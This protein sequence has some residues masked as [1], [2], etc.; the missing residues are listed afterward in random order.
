[1]VLAAT[2]LRNVF[3]GDVERLSEVTFSRADNWTGGHF[4]RMLRAYENWLGNGVELQILRLVGFADGPM[5]QAQIDALTSSPIPGVTDSIV[6]IGR[7]EWEHAVARLRKC[8][9]L[10]K[11]DTL[12]AHPLIREYFKR[13][14]R[15]QNPEGWAMAQKRLGRSAPAEIAGPLSLYV[16]I[17]GY[18]PEQ[19][20][21]VVVSLSDIY[22]T[23]SGDRLVIDG[24]GLVERTKIPEPSGA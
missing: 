2:Y 13:E 4:G 1:L 12:N 23:L 19:I 3:G 22:E 9:L 17:T 5:S 21:Q 14:I 24:Q 16:D 15:E 10:D 11:S 6:G 20:A 18:T 7:R 8:H